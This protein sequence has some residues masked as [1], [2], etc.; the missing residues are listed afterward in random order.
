MNNKQILEEID[1]I[2]RAKVDKVRGDLKNIS[3][4]TSKAVNDIS[5]NFKKI[6]GNLLK[7]AISKSFESASVD[8]LKTA[9]KTVEKEQ[10]KLFSKFRNM[11]AIFSDEDFKK[12]DEA[13]SKI[14]VISEKLQN[15]GVSY[16]DINIHPE[17]KSNSPSSPIQPKN[18]FGDLQFYTLK[19]QIGML[20]EQ[21]KNTYPVINTLANDFKKAINDSGSLLSILISKFNELKNSVSNVGTKI[22]STFNKVKTYVS[23]AFQNVFESV[24]QKI[25]PIAPLLKTI[26]VISKSSIQQA[27]GNLKEYSGSFKSPIEKVKNL[28]IKI[29]ETG[30]ETQK[31]KKKIN[32]FGTDLSKSF[33][34]GIKSI[35]KFALSLLSVRT[36]FSAISRASQSY[37]SFN[38]E[39]SNS[40]QNS[41]NVLGSLLAP[42]LEYVINLFSKLVSV[43]AQF[44]KILTG[45]DL[46]ARANAKALDKQAKSANKAN[47]L[48]S[49]DDIN[50]LKSSDAQGGENATLKVDKVDTKPLEKFINSVKKML[51]KVFDPFKEAWESVGSGV[52]ESMSEMTSNLGE[53]GSSVTGSFF[54]VWNNG[55]GQEIIENFLLQFQQILDII[56]GISEALSNVWNNAGTGTSIIQSIA[57]I[58]KD[59][60]KLG[61]LIG[62]SILKWVVSEEFQIALNKIFKFVDDIFGIIKDVCGWLVDMYAT[63]LKPVIDDKLLP[64]INDIIIALSDVWNFLKPLVDWVVEIVKKTLEPVIK[65]LC[66]FIGGIIDVIRG[67]VQFI[68][69][70]FTG[71]WKK[72]WNGIKTIFKGIWDALASIIKTPINALLAGI[73]FMINKLIDGFN[74]LKRAL[75]K[76]SFD[77]PDWIPVIGGK[78][79][80]FN[81]QESAQ[82]KL[83][84]LANGNVAYEETTAIFGEYANARHNPEITSPVSIMEETF[85]RVLAN[86]EDTGTRVERLV[87]NVLDENF[88]DGTIDYINNESVRRGVS[89]IKEV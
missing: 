74:L 55:T 12:M 10:E 17:I 51:D 59:I 13:A 2:V 36:A 83:P 3:K 89:V 71:D 70:V 29:R 40:L 77:I 86:H 30:S 43:V 69:G 52:L 4:E 9:L 76:I 87:L 75:N 1:I 78:K 20:N 73:E 19:E 64:A 7:D 26:G 60:Q 54:E 6:N 66:D 56:G 67:I 28:I 53:L 61:L 38:N 25:G 15:M 34:N 31:Q 72:A 14:E 49:I 63:Y 80:G 22:T 68:S 81:L 41:W 37:L 46:V 62:D 57:N 88:Y 35:K 21:I 5:K 58:F 82:I 32:S 24:K 47:S 16:E 11:P 42:A 8:D 23:S 65:G 39:L 27:R 79:W 18:D 45:I 44:V 85:D 50:V 84:R 33:H 48:S